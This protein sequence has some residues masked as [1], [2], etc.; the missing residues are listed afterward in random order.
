[1][2]KGKPLGDHSPIHSP[3]SDGTPDLHHDHTQTLGSQPPSS[4]RAPIDSPPCSRISVSR[5]TYH[6]NTHTP[7]PTSLLTLNQYML[8]RIRMKRFGLAVYP[9][10]KRKRPKVAR[11][12]R[13]WRPGC[14]KYT[15]WRLSLTLIGMA[16]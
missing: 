5:T 13:A 6:T 16:S 11:K 4:S 8:K 1:M 3:S 2:E 14:R 15:A 10:L 12:R 7:T 9:P